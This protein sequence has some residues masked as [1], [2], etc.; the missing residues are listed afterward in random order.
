[1]IMETEFKNTSKPEWIRTIIASILSIFVGLSIGL[2]LEFLKSSKPNIEYTYSESDA[3]KGQAGSFAI[4]K[5]QVTNSGKKEL[6]DVLAR[7]EG[8]DDEFLEAKVSGIPPS[9]RSHRLEKTSFQLNVP[10]LNPLETVSAQI[11]ISPKTEKPETPKIEVRAKGIIGHLA[12]QSTRDS[13]KRQIP[14]LLAAILSA[15]FVLYLLL[16]R[17]RRNAPR[18]FYTKSHRD[19]QRDV[20]SFILELNGLNDEAETIRRSERTLSYWAEADR[21]TN[22][23]LRLEDPDRTRRLAK[24]F[25]QLLYYADIENTSC[26]L[27]NTDIAKLYSKTGEMEKAKGAISKARS[28]NHKVIEKRIELD[29]TLRKLVAP[30]SQG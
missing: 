7:I 15:F 10:F 30:D 12:E 17:I 11:L 28:K 13:F 27:I 4:L 3:F 24:S 23:I 14:P 18:I 1:M 8:G 19:D 26:M 16:L 9:T 20:L 6:E 25:E 2:L 5:L 22:K 29:E 21:L